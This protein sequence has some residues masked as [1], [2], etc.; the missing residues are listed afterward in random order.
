MERSS[1]LTEPALDLLD[2]QMDAGLG[3]IVS[4]DLL[5]V[6]PGYLCRS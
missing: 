5:L 4:L 6:T 2:I 1:L 3:V